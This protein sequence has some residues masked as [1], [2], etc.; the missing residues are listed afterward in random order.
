MQSILDVCLCQADAGL[1]EIV[2][3]CSKTFCMMFKAKSARST[4]IPLLTLG[5]LK[6]KSVSCS[7]YVGIVLDIELSDDKDIQR[8]MR[9]Q[10]EVVIKLRASFSRCSNA[11]KNVLIRSFCRSMYAS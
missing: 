7:K 8:Q 2:F 10:Y 5:V 1:H 9:Y 11:V 6:I 4:A 3:N